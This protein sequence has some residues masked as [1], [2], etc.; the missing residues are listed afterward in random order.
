MNSLIVRSSH[1]GHKGI[2]LQLKEP[3]K[4]RLSPRDAAYELKFFNRNAESIHKKTLKNSVLK[5]EYCK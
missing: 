4:S 3:G 1:A 5:K 2:V